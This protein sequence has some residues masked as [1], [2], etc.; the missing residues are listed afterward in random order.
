MEQ[1]LCSEGTNE[2]LREYDLACLMLHFSRTSTKHK[3]CRNRAVLSVGGT[4]FSLFLI[5]GGVYQMTCMHARPL[6]LFAKL[7]LS[8]RRKLFVGL[9]NLTSDPPLPR[10]HM[11]GQPS[12]QYHSVLPPQMHCLKPTGNR[13]AVQSTRFPPN[14]NSTDISDQ[15]IYESSS[16][17]S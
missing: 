9:N 11:V 3:S 8:R 1:G 2:Q 17:V 15:I 14:L 6:F 10:D 12:N 7:N 13:Q 5:P 16:I 4:Y